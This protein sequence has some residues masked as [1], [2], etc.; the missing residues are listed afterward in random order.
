M[1][2]RRY[3]RPPVFVGPVLIHYRKNFASFLFFAAS[4]IGLRKNLESLRVF[5]TDS[6]KVVIDSFSHEFRFAIHL[7]C[8]IHLRKNVKDELFRRKFSDTI[9][10]I[11]PVI[12]LVSK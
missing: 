7:F 1:T 8:S 12:Y 6:D 11:L 10:V 4:L 2:T 5:G 3:N 9:A